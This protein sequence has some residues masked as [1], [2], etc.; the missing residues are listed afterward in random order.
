M[1][2]KLTIFFIV[3]MAIVGSDG[4]VHITLVLLS[5]MSVFFA[6]C[7]WIAKRNS[8]PIETEFENNDKPIH[9]ED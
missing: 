8:W 9:N 1:K 6:V 5:V 4:V 7:F 3:T 2:A